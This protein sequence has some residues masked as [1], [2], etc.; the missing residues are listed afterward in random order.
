MFIEFILFYNIIDLTNTLVNL[1]KLLF[2]SYW[3]LKKSVET[4]NNFNT[5]FT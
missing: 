5:I 3:L 1:V 2:F 4:L